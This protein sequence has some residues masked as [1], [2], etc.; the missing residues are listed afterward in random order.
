MAQAI[1][2]PDPLDDK[3]A[4]ANNADDLLAQLAGEEVDRLLSEADVEAVP[5]ADP[6]HPANIDLPAQPAAIPDQ[7]PSLDQLFDQFDG[8]QPAPSAAPNQSIEESLTQR[9][10]DL[11]EQARLE[12]GQQVALDPASTEPSAA[13]DLAA[14]MDADEQAH[15]AAM[16][17]VNSADPQPAALIDEAQVEA[18]AAQEADESPI[19]QSVPFVV[20]LLEWINSPLANLSET[21]RHALGKVALVTTVN[22]L[23]VLLYVLLFRRH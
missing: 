19:E 7:E 21:A 5:G 18:A 3:P 9:A 10:Q 4:G 17:R 14:E 15:L 12:A 11:I 8:P 20:R 2:L 16:L 6:L 13:A 1:D 23:A 22:A